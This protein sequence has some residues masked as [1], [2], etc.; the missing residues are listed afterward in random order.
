MPTTRILITNDGKVIAEGIG[1]IG[2]ECLRD[3]QRLQEILKS[4]GIELNIEM[5]RRKEEAAVASVQEIQ[6]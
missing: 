3:L 2:D 4:L 6:Q 1:Y 5:Q